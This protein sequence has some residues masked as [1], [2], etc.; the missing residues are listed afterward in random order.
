MLFAGTFWGAT[1]KG[2]KSTGNVG[3]AGGKEGTRGEKANSWR[4]L[5]K[6][7]LGGERSWHHGVTGR[8]TKTIK[9]KP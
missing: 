6:V 3:S 4:L 5:G 8:K 2:K 7:G 1:V 9:G